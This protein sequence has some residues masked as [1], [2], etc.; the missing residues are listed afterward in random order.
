MKWF[1]SI[2]DRY[3]E[4][5]QGLVEYALILVLVGVVVIAVLLTVGPQ[6]GAVFSRIVCTLGT[7]GCDVVVIT[8]A[9]CDPGDNKLKVKATSDGGTDPSVTL[10]V[11]PGGVME[12]DGNKYE[13]EIEGLGSC[14]TSVTVTSSGGGSATAA[15]TEDD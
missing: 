1:H 4:E 2:K 8:K 11:S 9:E 7:E 5:G 14:P 3:F 13:L 15:V 6:V 10:T 12:I